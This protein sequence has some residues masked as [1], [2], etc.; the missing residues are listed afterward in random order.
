MNKVR[1]KMIKLYSPQPIPD[2]GGAERERRR[3]LT[4]M[5]LLFFLTL[6]E[7]HN[8]VNSWK[9]RRKISWCNLN[10]HIWYDWWFKKKMYI[11]QE[12]N[13]YIDIFRVV[14][15]VVWKLYLPFDMT[16]PWP[17]ICLSN[18]VFTSAAVVSILCNWNFICYVSDNQSIEGRG[19]EE[20]SVTHS[21]LHFLRADCVAPLHTWNLSGNDWPLPPFDQSSTHT[22]H[23]GIFFLHTCLPS[24][25]VYL[26]LSLSSKQTG[27]WFHPLRSDRQSSV[28]PLAPKERERK[29]GSILIQPAY[30]P[31]SLPPQ[32]MIDNEEKRSETHLP[33]ALPWEASG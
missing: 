12:S 29:H 31:L 16:L 9:K 20:K 3:K 10:S 28:K 11:Y 33:C 27:K 5:A 22:P 18:D 14:R 30:Q 24:H 1:G 17:H 6:P 7:S 4:L 2:P 13:F 21:T 19:E 25:H 32:L 8:E 26:S 23:F 15:E